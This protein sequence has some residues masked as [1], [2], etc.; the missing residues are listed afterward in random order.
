MSPPTKI[1]CPHCQTALTIDLE[2]GPVIE[3]A[4]QTT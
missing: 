2:A 3:T 4:Y 1:T